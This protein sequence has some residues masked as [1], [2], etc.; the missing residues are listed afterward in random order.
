[1]QFTNTICLLFLIPL[2]AYI[3]WYILKGRKISPSMKVSTTMP[4]NKN[5]RSY[6]NY[7]IHIP[8]ALRVIALAMLVIVL[9]RPVSTNKWS[10]EN[11]EGI[12]I[13]LA[14]DVS[15]SM[16]AND[17]RPSRMKV[18]KEVA[19][20]F[21]A[22]RT[23][24]NI[25]LTL[26][27]GESFTQ[28]PLTTDYG[29]ILRFI[30]KSGY[31]YVTNET[32]SDGTAIG[33]GIANAISRLKDSKAKSKVIILLT[34][35]SNNCGEITPEDAAEYAAKFGIRIYTIGFRTQN[36]IVQTPWGLM[37][38]SN[39]DERTLRTIASSTGGQYFASSSKESLQNIYREIDVLERT[40]MQVKHFG[41]NEEEF[42]IFAIIALVAVLLEL[43]LRN[44]LLKRIP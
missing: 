19:A 13:M 22:G 30:D 12:D 14:M 7:L 35:G 42:M 41:T 33:M 17:I 15:T 4:Y 2:I 16:S 5:L 43:L 3:I 6:R 38:N 40:K 28:C 27:S 1:M 21:V 36:E 44:T 31:E 34:D 32:L 37:D 23:S 26:F 18:A 11:V 10:E 9:M 39:F 29:T 8:F 20:Q 24:D 25:G